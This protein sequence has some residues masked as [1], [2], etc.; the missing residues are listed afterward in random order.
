MT[1][2]IYTHSLFLAISV[3]PQRGFSTASIEDARLISNFGSQIEVRL[4]MKTVLNSEVVVAYSQCPRKA[5]LLFCTKEKGT[6]HEY[7]QIIEQRGRATRRKYI[8]TLKQK[9]PDVQ[10]YSTDNLKKKSDFL[11]NAKLQAGGLEAG[12]SILT[13]VKGSSSLGRYS[14]EP[15]I[16]VGTHRIS[17]EQRL[18]LAFVA[19]PLCLY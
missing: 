4:A 1:L 3:L 2:Y 7:V 5:F 16:F 15:T 12:C 9:C 8:K 6:P 10:P 18:E 14:Y 13:K 17:K 19:H 11:I